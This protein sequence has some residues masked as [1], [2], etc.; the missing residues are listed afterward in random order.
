MIR[1]CL[2]QRR[3]LKARQ[4]HW[5]SRYTAR[6]G[7]PSRSRMRFRPI[8]HHR[9]WC[10]AI[11]LIA[12]QLA[13]AAT[14]DLPAQREAF[15]AALAAASGQPSETSRQRN[16]MLRESHYPLYPYVELAALRGNLKSRTKAEIE[17]FL[18][19]FPDTLPASDLRKAWLRELARRGDWTTFTKFQV[20]SSDPELQCIALQAR[21]AGGG[22]LDYA[23]DLEALWM[24]E[25]PLPAACAG[26]VTSARAR[27]VLDADKV[28]ARLER[29]M[30]A[31]NVDAA[32][33][34]PA[35][36]D[37]ADRGAAE[38]IV[39][40][41]RDPPATLAKAAQWTD[42][43]RTRDAVSWALARLARRD[44]AAAET[45][46][47]ALQ[48]RF[49][50]D[51]AQKDR[52]L[53]ALALYRATS[54]SPDAM[55]R[56][57]AL[58]A[59]AEDDPT[60]EWRVRT[61]LAR[62]DFAATLDALERMS[63]AQKAD[64]RWRYLRA[65]VL[66]KLG[67]EAEARSL[68]AEVAREANFHG[69]LAADWLDAPYTICPDTLAGGAQVEARLA[70]QGDLARAFEFRELGMLRDA[71]R[72]WSFAMGKLDENDRRLAADY[73]YRKGWYDRAVFAFSADPST[74]RLYEQ[75]FPLGLAETMHRQSRDAGIDPSWAYGILRAESAWMTDARSSAN[76]Y[77]LMQL[78][79]SVGK[80]VA[81]SLDLR[82]RGPED[83]YDPE[84]NVRLG[85][86]YLAQ[87][88]A[89]Y[90]GSPWLASAA[91]NA[92]EGAV[93]RW[94][95]VRGTLDPDFF[96]ETIPY[97]ETREYVAR[98]MAFSVIYDWRLNGKVLALASRMPRIGQAYQVPDAQTPRKEVS[99]PAGAPAADT[100]TA[101][102]SASTTT[103]TPQ[104]A[105]SQ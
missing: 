46:W 17:A 103:P 87:M 24:R 35:L 52:V 10:A 60:R 105:S 39:A 88:A 94:I 73:A 49:A 101:T 86:H 30:L 104:P 43:P 19:R 62:A 4:P 72:E 13:S 6:V 21:L 14:P 56:L 31:G 93:N 28:W 78:L 23:R 2:V 47:A 92:G 22:K 42:G 37:G 5:A 67:R 3:V 59:T 53:N 90:D 58:P 44:S 26:A 34:M 97:R 96:V 57:D 102:S 79:P 41:L 68:L 15:R 8:A 85:T 36:L 84:F 70:Q 64:A 38:R 54:Y 75:R 29:S 33:A 45:A 20:A 95:G 66:G 48:A 91:Y 1:L 89:S 27:G 12:V 25:R 51:Q 61:A 81:K 71:R 16:A 9:S 77:G 82:Y 40:A 18:E 7:K 32:A 100:A 50:W 11:F 65:R 76:A 80:Q 98:V 63:D 55:A 74:Q 83:L 69:F 99:C